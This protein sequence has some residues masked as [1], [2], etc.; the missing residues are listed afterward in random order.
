MQ[1]YKFTA[2]EPP[3]IALSALAAAKPDPVPVIVNRVGPTC[4]T[5]PI[6]LTG[7][8]APLVM[9][10]VATPVAIPVGISKLICPGDTY[11]RAAG[12]DLPVKSCTETLTSARVSGKG[13]DA[14]FTVAA[15]RFVP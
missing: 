3:G 12:A 2:D 15:E 11:S 7:G 13:S 8:F 6:A 14:A 10:N 1:S 4:P 9:V 5:A